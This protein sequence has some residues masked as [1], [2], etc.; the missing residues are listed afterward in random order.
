MGEYFVAQTGMVTENCTVCGVLF[1]IT[2]DYQY[3]AEMSHETFYCP[4]GH[5][6]H[7]P[8]KTSE[9]KK[10]ENLT[11]QNAHLNECCINYQEAAQ[12]S[13]RQVTAY[14]GVVTKLKQKSGVKE[15]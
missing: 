7:Y 8:E 9:E 13:K 3:R 6:Q 12:S 5:G 10:I 14:K 4:N 15:V 2:K 11:A 1:A